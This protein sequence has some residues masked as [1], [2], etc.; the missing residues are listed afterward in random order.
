[1]L[2]T[3]ITLFCAFYI[4]KSQQL[5]KISSTDDLAIKNELFDS[6]LCLFNEIFYLA[7][8][9]IDFFQYMIVL[10]YLTT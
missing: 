5:G 7:Q 4:L 2:T 8:K 10:T 1:M 6:S 9:G 3:P